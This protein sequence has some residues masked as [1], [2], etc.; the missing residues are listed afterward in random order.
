[1]VKWLSEIEIAC[2]ES[3]SHYY[4]HDNRLLPSSVASLDRASKEEW[5]Y[6]PEYIIGE[7][8]INAVITRPSHGDVVLLPP[9]SDP[10]STYKLE[11]ASF[12]VSDCGEGR[13]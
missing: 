13:R 9:Q 10:P 7:M 12:C 5:W 11:V 6:R 1:M 4:F 8:N 2:H 3:E